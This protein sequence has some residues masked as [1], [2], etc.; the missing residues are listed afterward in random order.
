MPIGQ[1]QI[2]SINYVLKN[3]DGNI[4]D[5]TTNGE[6]FAFLSGHEQILPKLEEAISTMLIGAKKEITLQ[7]A[8]AYGEYREE[9][10]QK[11]NRSDFPEDAELQEGVQFYATS[12]D[13]QNIP[14]T[15]RSIEDDTVTIDFNHPLAGETLTFEVELLDVREATPEEIS[16]GHAHAAGGHEH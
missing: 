4:L 6:P 7:P 12:P 2:V 14:F 13:G 16:H 8:E 5:S 1:D 9:S 3:E 15:I 11:A 10:V